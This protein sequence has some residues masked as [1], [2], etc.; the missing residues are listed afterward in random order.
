MSNE[1]SPREVCSITIGINGLIS[2]WL[3]AAGSPE[4]RLCRRLFLVGCPDCLA[5]GGLLGW[6]ALDLVRHAVEGAGKADVLALRLVDARGAGLLDHLVGLVEA[7]SKH[8]VHVL[9]G[10]LDAELVGDG[11]EHELA[12]NRCGG[13]LAQASD[14]VLGGVARGS[15]VS[16]DRRAAS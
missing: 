8:L 5:G 11:F 15:E 3:L 6:D 13:L 12:G 14:Q 2:G 16:L 7:R 9:V 1:R 10:N 4:F